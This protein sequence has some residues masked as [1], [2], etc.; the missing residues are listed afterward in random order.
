MDRYRIARDGKEINEFDL[1]AIRSYLAAGSL[2]PTDHAWKAGM[3]GWKTLA[4]LGIATVPPPAP[5]P[6]RPDP[7]T[8]VG[9]AAP[10]GAPAQASSLLLAL[11]IFFLP[12][13]IYVLLSKKYARRSK[14]L[15]GGW[16]AA[17]LFMIIFISATHEHKPGPYPAHQVYVNAKQFVPRALKSPSTA[18]FPGVVGD[19]AVQSYDYFTDGTIYV[20]GVS[21]WVDAQNSFGAMIRSN[22]QAWYMRDGSQVSGPLKPVWIRIGNDDALGSRKEIERLRELAKQPGGLQSEFDSN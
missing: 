3:P 19:D 6:A 11:G 9:V 8:P 1:D 16:Y 22:W 2:R 17:A 5:P 10:V 4:E 7:A 12:V 15:I 14:V 21:S 20:E 18:R 13:G